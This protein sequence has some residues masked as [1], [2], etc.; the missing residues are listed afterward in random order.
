VSYLSPAARRVILT[1]P[2]RNFELARQFGVSHT[3]IYHVRKD[4]VLTWKQHH[5][6]WIGTSPSMRYPA[7]IELAGA[8]GGYRLDGGAELYGTLAAA[9]RAAV[10]N[11]ERN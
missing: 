6:R 4:G 10:E 3:A 8:G 2:L 1:S 9:K 11:A 7:V 5:T